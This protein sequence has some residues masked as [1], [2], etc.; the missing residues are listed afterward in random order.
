MNPPEMHRRKHGERHTQNCPRHGYLLKRNRCIQGYKE[1]PKGRRCLPLD[2]TTIRPA[3]ETE[4]AE[5][6]QGIQLEAIILSAGVFRHTAISHF[7]PPAQKAP[8][9]CA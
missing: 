1:S 5:A 3:R 2:L 8:A 7:L 6:H 9:R 4:L